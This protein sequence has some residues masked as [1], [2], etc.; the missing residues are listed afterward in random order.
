MIDRE[1]QEK[2][3]RAGAAN[4]TGP[5][6]CCG[7]RDST[8]GKTREI[9]L[10]CPHLGVIVTPLQAVPDPEDPRPEPGGSAETA[11]TGAKRGALVWEMAGKV[12][13]P[14]SYHNT[15]LAVD[16]LGM[17]GRYDT[18]HDRKIVSG[19]LIENLGDELSEPD[20][21]RGARED[22]RPVRFRPRQR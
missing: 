18:F 20:R 2:W 1:T 15:R 13:K 9:C 10:A 7:Y 5:P 11:T 12:I 14:K 3:D 21:A 16:K 8:D 22:C 19:D 4:L 17:T 6:L